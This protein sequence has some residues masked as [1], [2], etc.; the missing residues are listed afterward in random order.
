[1]TRSLYCTSLVVAAITPL[2]MAIEKKEGSCTNPTTASHPP[3]SESRFGQAAVREAG[4]RRTRNTLV[5]ILFPPMT[6]TSR[7]WCP[8]PR[9]HTTL[10]T[11]T[12][13][14]LSTRRLPSDVP[15][16]IWYRLG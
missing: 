15:L 14:H 1:M 3:S 13:T 9:K 5:G 11:S 4:T 16:K 7:T 10:S 12:P 8:N 2:P 6:W